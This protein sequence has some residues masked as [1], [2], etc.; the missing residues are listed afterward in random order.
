M[1][2]WYNREWNADII[3]RRASRAMFLQHIS[4]AGA[5]QKK[6]HLSPNSSITYYNLFF[7]ALIQPITTRK[8]YVTFCGYGRISYDRLLQN[9]KKRL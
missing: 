3:T 5:A 1:P 8:K 9:K 7:R 4:A 6:N 2:F